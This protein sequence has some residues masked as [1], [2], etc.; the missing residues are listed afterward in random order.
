MLG[1]LSTGVYQGRMRGMGIGLDGDWDSGL[2]WNWDLEGV[3]LGW[4]RT[5]VMY[6]IAKMVNGSVKLKGSR[7][8]Q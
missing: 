7:V 6:I 5:K 1:M 3:G 8:L 2:A 4:F